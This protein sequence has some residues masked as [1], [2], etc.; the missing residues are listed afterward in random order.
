M[1][2]TRGRREPMNTSEPNR[3][4]ASTGD[5]QASTTSSPSD[6]KPVKL[7]KVADSEA[8]PPQ[9]PTPEPAVISFQ[10]G[11]LRVRLTDQAAHH[12]RCLQRQYGYDPRCYAAEMLQLFCVGGFVADRGVEI[13][14]QH[15]NR[16][17]IKP[18]VTAPEPTRA[19]QL[20]RALSGHVD[21]E[22]WTE[23]RGQFEID[24]LW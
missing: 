10:F 4:P 9:R 12:V 20:H 5:K 8:S 18:S 13:L 22:I 6:A 19:E 2:E 21:T 14:D 15:N 7:R 24:V 23:M 1:K 11:D 16:V 17:N 3:Q